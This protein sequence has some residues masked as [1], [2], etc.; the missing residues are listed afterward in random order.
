MMCLLGL[1]PGDDLL[2]VGG[3]IVRGV[4]GVRRQV[5]NSRTSRGNERDYLKLVLIL[6]RRKELTKKSEEISQ[7]KMFNPETSHTT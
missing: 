4:R 5:E 1:V 2:D 6:K 7:I 3:V